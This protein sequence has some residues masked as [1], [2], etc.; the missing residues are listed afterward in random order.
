[1]K[2]NVGVSRMMLLGTLLTLASGC[3]TS[4]SGGASGPSDRALI[5]AGWRE[6]VPTLADVDAMS[7][8]LALAIDGHNANG[9][10]RGCW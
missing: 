5:C 10:R 6:I 7:D 3:A 9:E 4:P 2:P 1:M 8:R